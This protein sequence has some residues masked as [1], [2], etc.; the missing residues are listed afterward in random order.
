MSDSHEHPDGWQCV[1][2]E[3]VTNLLLDEALPDEVF[4]AVVSATVLI[5]T[6]RGEVPGATASAKWP[7]QR[8][9][10]L[11]P[12]GAFGLAEYVIVAHAEP[13]QI[14]LTRVQLY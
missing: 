2:S 6:T 1:L 13:P 5:N 8:R 10:P 9:M 4:A 12:D 7:E 11:G 14:V 3:E